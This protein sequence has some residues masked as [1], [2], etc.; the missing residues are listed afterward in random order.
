MT[1]FSASALVSDA[2]LQAAPPPPLATAALSPELAERV[3]WTLLHSVWQGL[4]VAVLLALALGL[5][6]ASTPAVRS[7]AA[8]MALLAMAGAG[9][10]TFWVLGG[11]DSDGGPPGTSVQVADLATGDAGAA[12]WMA[13]SPLPSAGFKG[14]TP[15]TAGSAA[16]A[17]VTNAPAAPLSLAAPPKARTGSAGI[18]RTLVQW[19]VL[20]WAGGVVALSLLRLGGWLQLQRLLRSARDVGAPWDARVRAL[21]RRLR[22]SCPVRLAEAG[23]V[24][25]PS[26]AGALRPVVLLPLGALTGLTPS[27]LEALIAHELAH[28]RRHDYLFNLVQVAVETLLFYHPAVWWVSGRVREEREH[29]CDDLA[30]AACGGD[31]AAYAGALA[32][33]AALRDAGASGRAHAPPHLALA[34]AGNRRDGSLLRRVRRLLAAP[35]LTSRPRGRRSLAGTAALV[36]PILMLALVTGIA[37]V[38]SARAGAGQADAAAKEDAAAPAATAQFPGIDEPPPGPAVDTEREPT[39]AE[40][41]LFERV[42]TKYGQARAAIESVQYDYFL[43]MGQGPERAEKGRFARAGKRMYHAADR[44][45]GETSWDGRRAY[46]RHP[47]NDQKTRLNLRKGKKDFQPHIPMFESSFDA[48]VFWALGFDPE[49][50]PGFSGNPRPTYRLLAA[51]EVDDPAHGECIELT[52][53]LVSDSLRATHVMRHARR[54]GYAP[55][56]WRLDGRLFGKFAPPEGKDEY[57]HMMTEVRF[58]TPRAGESERHYPVDFTQMQFNPGGHVSRHRFWIDE[59]TLKINEP[60]PRSRFV[61]KPW[62]N[63]DSYDFRTKQDIKATDPNWSPIGKVDFPWLSYLKATDPAQ[64]GKRRVIVD[65]MLQSQDGKGEQPE[66]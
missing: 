10:V 14:R 31:P 9:L 60:I 58:A 5:L 65:G 59:A 3:A 13:S 21:A 49:L 37:A 42:K 52:Y 47:M 33:M 11:S 27:Q 34:A 19:V 17:D 61:L 2:L 48:H 50:H 1:A 29:C 55:V 23:W 18:R 22:V 26:V 64:K 43:D 38:R 24:A 39:A 12:A 40:R 53:E 4:G 6:R 41:E 32:A 16:P 56:Y 25:V 28:V 62:P 15:P 8:V 46:T 36:V 51:R 7:R 35:A 57:R 66:N 20:G 45:W 30:V 63:S 44:V 54:H